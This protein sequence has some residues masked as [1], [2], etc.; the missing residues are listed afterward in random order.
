MDTQ[1]RSNEVTE[2]MLRPLLR[3]GQLVSAYVSLL[4]KVAEEGPH[5]AYKRFGSLHRREMS[6]LGKA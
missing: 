2:G 1:G 3:M 4:A 6:P 5:I